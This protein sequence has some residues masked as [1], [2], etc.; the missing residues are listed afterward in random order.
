MPDSRIER[1]AATWATSGDLANEHPVAADHWRRQAAQQVALLEAAGLIVADPD[2]ALVERVCEALD[3]Y[4]YETVRLAAE[5]VLGAD[6]RWT[7]WEALSD[8]TKRI[9][10]DQFIGTAQAVVAALTVKP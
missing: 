8:R 10:H 2:D 5:A 6:G 3:R 1:V 9:R 4:Q 7:P